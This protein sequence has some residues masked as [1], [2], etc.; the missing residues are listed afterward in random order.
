[1]LKVANFTF[2]T[3]IYVNIKKLDIQHARVKITQLKNA[4]KSKTILQSL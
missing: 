3:L 2:L 1:M 4:N